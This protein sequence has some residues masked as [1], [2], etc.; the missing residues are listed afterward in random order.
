[1]LRRAGAES[2]GRLR[3]SQRAVN[4]LRVGVPSTHCLLAAYFSSTLNDFNMH[5]FVRPLVLAALM[6]GRWFL[7]RP[8]P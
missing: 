7:A 2:T 5:A 6:A 8:G 4:G 3:T 1:M